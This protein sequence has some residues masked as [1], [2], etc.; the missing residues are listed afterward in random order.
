MTRFLAVV[1]LATCLPWAGA[2]GASISI[3]NCY[4]DS[5]IDIK[6][7]NGTDLVRMVPISNTNGVAYRRTQILSCKTD[8]C[9]ASIGYGFGDKVSNGGLATAYGTGQANAVFSHQLDDTKTYCFEM[10]DSGR[11]KLGWNDCC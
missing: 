7:F 9:R 11:A 5:A 4:P 6:L 3:K 1:A 8:T 2:F 10:L